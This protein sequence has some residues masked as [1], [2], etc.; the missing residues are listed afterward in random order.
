LT[1]GKESVPVGVYFY[2]L[3]LNSELKKPIQGRIYLS[4]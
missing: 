1:I 2:V 3:E 4:R